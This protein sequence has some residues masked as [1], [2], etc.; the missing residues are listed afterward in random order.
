[1]PFRACQ[2]FMGVTKG[3]Y[4]SR[5]TALLT[6]FCK[7]A[8]KATMGVMLHPEIGGQPVGREKR[9]TKEGE[10]WQSLFF[11][12]NIAF[13]NEETPSDASVGHHELKIYRR[14]TT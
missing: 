14:C 4:H 9:Q 10:T 5:N 2:W 6:H 13:D 11:E 1:M 7:G 12:T 8:P 3:T